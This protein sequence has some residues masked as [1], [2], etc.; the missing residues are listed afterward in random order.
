LKSL[1]QVIIQQDQ[2]LCDERNAGFHCGQV[3]VSAQIPVSSD[4]DGAQACAAQIE[5]DVIRLSMVQRLPHSIV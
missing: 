1:G 2:L 4:M 3:K 5:W